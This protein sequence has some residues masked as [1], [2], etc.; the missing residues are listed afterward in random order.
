MA[1]APQLLR[2]C[3]LGLAEIAQQAGY[4][5]ASTFRVAFA[6]QVGMSPGRYARSEDSADAS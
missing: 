3:G 5:C 2:R 6:R 4:R 1:K